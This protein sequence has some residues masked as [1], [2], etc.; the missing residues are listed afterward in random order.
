MKI[1]G[2][3]VLVSVVVSAALAA[4][5]FIGWRLLWSGVVHSAER[6]EQTQ[7]GG[8]TTKPFASWLSQAD[9][10]STSSSSP[11]SSGSQSASGLGNGSSAAVLDTVAGRQNYYESL[12]IQPAKAIF[13]EWSK[14]ILRLNPNEMS[15]VAAALGHSLRRQTDADV[16]GGL[17]D[18]AINK[19]NSVASRL[20]AI[21][22]LMHAAT[23]EAVTQL[24]RFLRGTEA[25]SG[26]DAPKDSPDAQ[27]I[28]Q[29]LQAVN[30]SVR[31]LV[32]GSRNWN[33]SPPLLSAWNDATDETRQDVLR[34]LSS[35]IIYLGKPD[36]ID[37]F[38]QSV[39]Q[40][41]QNSERYK[42]ALRALV[43]IGSNDS[44]DV[45][46]AALQRYAFNQELSHALVRGLLSM[47]TAD[48]ILQVTRYMDRSGTLD[49][50]WHE[51]IKI[52]LQEKQSSSPE[53]AKVLSAWK[54]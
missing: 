38:V 32:E 33:S 52:K 34:S 9:A 18:Y 6:D 24:V 21:D 12:L 13:P 46:A 22:T 40:L 25:W 36:D 43:Q 47:G 14:A 3:S 8:N 41:N 16:Y 49:S 51:E 50:A 26:G 42:V 37:R 11:T 27:V 19:G 39:S 30:D 28:S 20:A 45:L 1:Y 5:F 35:G 29:A 17:G 48:S 54:G 15:T 10:P 53:V 44:V 2:R 31:T 7:S 23:P 4:T